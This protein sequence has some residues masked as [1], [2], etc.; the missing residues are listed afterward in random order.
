MGCQALKAIGAFSRR[1]PTRRTPCTKIRFSLMSFLVKNVLNAH[2]SEF[3]SKVPQR[4][5]VA[6]I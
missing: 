1:T 2:L 5:G 3:F 4:F 6:H